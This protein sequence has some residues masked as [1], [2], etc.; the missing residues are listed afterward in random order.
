MKTKCIRTNWLIPFV[1][2]AVVAATV[3]TAKAYLDLERQTQASEVLAVT[4]DRLYQDHQLSMA[5]KT[6]H[7]GDAAAAAR[8]LDLLL[9][10]HIVRL[11]SELASA[12]ARTRTYVEDAFQRIALV[13]PRVVQAQ[14]AN[15][16]TECSDDQIAAERILG[17]VSVAHHTALAN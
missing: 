9:C 5:L 11:D 2:I 10:E 12:D 16:A 17:R 13:R 3:A 15:S 7:D 4:L 14:S 8:R 1:G 6:L